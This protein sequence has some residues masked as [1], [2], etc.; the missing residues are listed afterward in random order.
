MAEIPADAVELARRVRDG[1]TD[2]ATLVG[3]ALAALDAVDGQLR[4]TVWRDDERARSWSAEAAD[5]PFA[6]VPFV[7]KDLDGDEAGVPNTGSSRFLVDHVPADDAPV[8][9]R[10][11]AAGFVFIA[12][13]NCPELGI[14]GTTEPELRGPTH[15]P[16]NLDH[17][18]GGS[19]GGS[20]ALVAAGVVPAAHGGDG[21]GSLRIPASAC[22]L[23]GL[24]PSRGRVPVQGGEGWGGFVQQGVITRSVRDTAAILDVLAGP[25]PGSPYTA[26]PLPGPLADEVGKEP[27][28]LRVAFSTASLYGEHTDPDCARAVTEAAALLEELGHEVIE[29]AP[30]LD[31]AALARGYLVQVAAGTAANVRGFE[32]LLGRRS[33]PSDW[34]PATWFLVQLGEKLSALQLQQARDLHHAAAHTMARFH[35]AHDVWLT[36]TLAHPPVRLGELALARRE[37]LGLA[38]LRALPVK[39]LMEQAL[40]QLASDS[41]EK[42]PNTQLFNQTGQPAMSLP[43]GWSSTGLPIGVQ[44]AAAY[45]REDLLV[46]L[47]AQ[48]ET[49]RPWAHRAPPVAS[50]WLR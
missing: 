26:P 49:A 41:L 36:P 3:E 15:N 6:G 35:E 50:A 24:K 22:G 34:E 2:A 46:R 9:A 28:K 18:V 44:V 19:S 39:A 37:R 31:T 29:A 1:E 48:V 43:L 13:T 12:R 20:A 40:D 4:A 47:A 32:T 5:G 14:M 10:L 45:G 30:A 17:S 8:I 38:A 33:S 23:F 11:K 27:G 21:G 7:V 16:W 25:A 42:T